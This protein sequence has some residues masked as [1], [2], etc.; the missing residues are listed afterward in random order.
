MPPRA[1]ARLRLDAGVQQRRNSSLERRVVAA[2]RDVVVA[3]R[4]VLA[5]RAVEALSRF[6]QTDLDSLIALTQLLRSASDKWRA[7][8]PG[9]PQTRRFGSAYA[10]LTISTW[11]AT[12]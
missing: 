2:V 11:R 3:P 1:G 10:S 9:G 6:R 5:L 7:A 12:S 8:Q 4:R